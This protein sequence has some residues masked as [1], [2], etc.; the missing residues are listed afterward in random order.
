MNLFPVNGNIEPK[1]HM[2]C[3]TT[4]PLLFYPFFPAFLPILALSF[5]SFEHG[6]AKVL[7]LSDRFLPLKHEGMWL[8]M[9]RP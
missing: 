7:E 2:G 4:P 8:V 9:V 5:L 3:C 1:L 6:E